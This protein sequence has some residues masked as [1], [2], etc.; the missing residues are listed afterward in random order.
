M[1]SHTVLSFIIVLASI[2]VL[3]TAW[4]YETED[5][6]LSSDLNRRELLRRIATQLAGD[7]N[8]EKGKIDSETV[9]F[10]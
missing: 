5:D 3:A 6:G 7:Q 4:N 9:L 2:F 8:T 1:Q 10:I